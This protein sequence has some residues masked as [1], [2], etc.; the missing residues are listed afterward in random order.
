MCR[1]NYYNLTTCGGVWRTK[2]LATSFGHKNN[3]FCL[4]QELEIYSTQM[5]VLFYL[6]LFWFAN[7]FDL[8]HVGVSYVRDSNLLS[9]DY[10]EIE[11]LRKNLKSKE[12]ANEEMMAEEAEKV[13]RKLPPI[14]PSS[15]IWGT[16]CS[17]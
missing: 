16:K 11:S 5:C 14:S 13:I 8:L 12:E 2:L 7:W 15:S 1:F 6:F 3:D 17:Y 9:F 4:F 10:L